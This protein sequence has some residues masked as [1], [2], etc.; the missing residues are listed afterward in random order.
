MGM[1]T[2]SSGA[3]GLLDDEA[4]GSSDHVSEQ[5]ELTPSDP[6][7]GQQ[8]HLA[9]IAQTTQA[10]WSR[11]SIE[12]IWDDHR[13]Q[14]VAVAVYDDG[15]EATHPDLAG[16]YVSGRHISI[17]GNA[18]TGAPAYSDDNHGTAVAGIIAAAN[19]GI[20]GVGVAHGAQ[21]TGVRTLGTGSPQ[22]NDSLAQGGG[23]AVINGSYGFGPTGQF[24]PNINQST[25]QARGYSN[26]QEWTNTI[27]SNLS[28]S[29]RDGLGTIYVKSAGNA[30]NDAGFVGRANANGDPGNATRFSI[31]VAAFGDNNTSSSYS[32]NGANILVAAPSTGGSRGITTTDRVGSPGYTSG[33]STSSFGGTSAAAPV[34]SGVAALMLSANSGLGWRDV[35]DI[36]AYSST[37]VGGGFGAAARAN[38]EFTWGFNGADNWNGGGLHFSQDYGFGAVNAHNAVRM[39]EVWSLF[40]PRDVS[41]NEANINGTF[42]GG[43]IPERGNGVLER[44][45]S[46]SNTDFQIDSVSVYVDLTHSYL[47]DLDI[48]LVSPD[49]TTAVLMYNWPSTTLADNGWTWTFNAQNFRGEDLAGNWTLRIRDEA[50]GDVGTLNGAA[51]TFHGTQTGVGG[52][53]VANDVYHYTDEAIWAV[54]QQA[55]RGVLHDADGGWD[56]INFSAVTADISLGLNGYDIARFS[57][58]G[59]GNG[60]Q[61]FQLSGTPNFEGVIGGDGNDFLI[62]NALDNILYGQRGTDILGGG[63]GND[64]LAGGSG[65]DMLYGDGGNDTLYGETGNDRL[66]GGSGNDVLYGQSGIDEIYGE[67]GDDTLIGGTEVDYLYGQ[68]GIDRLFGEQGSD[69]IFGGA[70]TDFLYGQDGGDYLY[71]E[72]GSDR[73]EGGSG[74]DSITGGQGNDHLFGGSEGD[75]FYFLGDFGRDR[76][77]DFQRGLDRLVFSL[78]ETNAVGGVGRT[79]D[80]ANDITTFYVGANYSV[81][82]LGFADFSDI[83]LA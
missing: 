42:A 64:V 65:N 26:Y 32:D 53:N 72:A 51:I 46:A 18:I 36:L 76:V 21:L 74:A 10:A 37:H 1:A 78:G 59:L 70:D 13:G 58:P 77:D 73:I 80:G 61:V 68:S 41:L 62:G 82:V 54:G 63:A 75:Y 56:W 14:G 43:A 7:Y 19:N 67:A 5:P 79:Y 6:L 38:E 44:T 52:E 28:S 15:V 31:D 83:V 45:L 9:R 69:A 11:A 47:R 60:V 50:G 2:F 35:H 40:G 25:A 22:V 24:S 4:F 23:F 12:A 66:V 34:V 3:A 48:E 8:W 27:L 29:G 57:A 71:G 81:G 39:A 17:N 20:G 30:N 33:D 16:N 49:G 55:S